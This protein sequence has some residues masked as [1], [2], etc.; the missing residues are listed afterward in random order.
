MKKEYNKEMYKEIRKNGEYKDN[1][2]KYILIDKKYVF[3]TWDSN[4]ITSQE[5][6]FYGVIDSKKQDIF[7][8]NNIE[9]IQEEL[10]QEAKKEI[11]KEILQHKE[12]YKNIQKDNFEELLKSENFKRG[13]DYYFYDSYTRNNFLQ[14]RS[15]YWKRLSRF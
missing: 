5:Y 9:E 11:E 2:Y 8:E 3:K 13:I 15:H 14:F 4:Y 10:I 12:E 1:Y 6:K 7:T